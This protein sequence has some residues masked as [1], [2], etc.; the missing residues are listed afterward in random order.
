M[1]ELLS[2]LK[3]LSDENRMRIL[4]ML[5]IRPVCVCEIEEVLDI[6]L[7]TVSQHLRVLK[8][9]GL[10]GDTKE[11][12]WV[13]YHLVEDNPHLASLLPGIERAAG[14]DPLIRRD[15]E[16]IMNMDRESCAM[17]FRER[18]KKQSG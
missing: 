6:A 9:A 12:R 10:I 18:R 2:I 14:G 17:R 13:I 3:A 15:R 4:L 5:R 1:K 16:K 7:S 8:Y 11:G